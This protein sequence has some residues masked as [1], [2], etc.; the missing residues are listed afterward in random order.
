MRVL[1]VS[2]S[3]PLPL[4]SGGRLRV[5]HLIRQLSARHRITLLTQAD[6]PEDVARHLP[7]LERFCERVIVVPWRSGMAAFAGRVLLGVRWWGDLPLS[8]LNKRSRMLARTLHALLGRERFDVVQIEWIQMA[9]HVHAADRPFLSRRGMLVAHDV[10]WLPLERRAQVTVGPVRWVW[11]REARLMRAYEE[12]VWRRVARVVAMSEDDAAR[13]RP[14]T[15]CVT[16]VP[17]GVDVAHYADCAREPRASKTLLFIG[18]FRHDPNVDAMRWFLESIYGLIVR[19]HPDARLRIVGAHAPR[20]IARP[21]ARWSSVDL[22]GYVEDVRPLLAD[23]MVSVVP[24]RVGGGTRLKILE[25]MAAGTPVVS[26]SVGCEGLAAEP[27]RHLLV[28]DTPE[29]FAEAVSDLL[30]DAARREYVAREALAFVRSRYDWSRAAE[31]LDGVY[32]SLV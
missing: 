27:G 22:V 17:N 9:Q 10:A 23:S 13:V 14:I 5:F 31:A 28:G 16:V 1:I 20:A 26:T 29:A 24:L 19:R 7:E 3:F 12:S 2:M 15:D 21:A 4:K 30:D 18:W 11:R 6:S 25:S 32:Q 8:V